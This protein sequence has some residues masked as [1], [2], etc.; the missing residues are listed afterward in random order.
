M[1]ILV[2]SQENSAFLPGVDIKKAA[3]FSSEI[4]YFLFSARN[5]LQVPE[6]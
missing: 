3:H 6:P 2:T 5:K 4:V 1:S